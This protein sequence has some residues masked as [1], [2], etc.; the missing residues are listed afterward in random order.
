MSARDGSD[1]A[2]RQQ[3]LENRN[4]AL[5]GQIDSML[6]DLRRRTAEI[7]QKQAE[8]AARTHEISSEDGMVTAT[9]DASGT[10][11][12]LEL[13]PKAFERSTPDR[14]AR[15]ITSLIREATGTA[16][17]ALHSE[18]AGLAETPDLPSIVDGAPMLQ[19]FFNGS[20]LFT[21]PDPQAEREERAAAG[22][23]SQAAPSRPAS[24]PQVRTA[25]EDDYD[26][27]FDSFMD[28][29]RRRW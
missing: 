8:A 26:D 12:K 15:T 29:R 14:L 7:Q 4:A 16:Q 1:P 27:D 6:S 18:F 22:S 20:P 2:A 25:P 10:L 13:S 11:Q 24:P 5:R 17:Q 23:S 9:V 19:D 21:P 3:D 28:D